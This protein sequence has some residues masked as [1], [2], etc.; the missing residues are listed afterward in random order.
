MGGKGIPAPSK[1]G[2][3]KYTSWLDKWNDFRKAN[4][5][6]ILEFPELTLQNAQQ[7]LIIA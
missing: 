5:L 3:G 2:N 7:L 1:A 6:D 4:W